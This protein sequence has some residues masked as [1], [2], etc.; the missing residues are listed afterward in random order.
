MNLGK[1]TF[2]DVDSAG[3]LGHSGESLQIT[4]DGRQA[5]RLL[6]DI[7]VDVLVPM[8]F[9]SWD[10]FKQQKEDL[11]EKFESEGILEKVLWLELRKKVKIY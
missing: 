10:H 3:Q 2:Y 8:H 4:M 1:A 9:E 6:K 5:G 7:G 11:S